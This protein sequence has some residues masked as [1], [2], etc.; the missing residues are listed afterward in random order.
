MREDV[1][2]C[3]CVMCACACA[4]DCDSESLLCPKISSIGCTLPSISFMVKKDA[5]SR[6]S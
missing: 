5:V 4:C 6:T 1:C 3:G 2:G